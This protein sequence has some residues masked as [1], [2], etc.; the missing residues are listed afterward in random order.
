MAKRYHKAGSGEYEGPDSRR[1]QEAKDFNMFHLNSDEVANMPQQ[2]MY[3]P[4]P[5]AGHYSDYGLD[6]TIGGID[7]QMDE[8][9]ETMRRHLQKGKY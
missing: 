2:V 7:K 5:K 3:K 8:D 6:D 4:W 1:K 9:G